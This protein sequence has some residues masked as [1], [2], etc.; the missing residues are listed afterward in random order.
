VAFVF[1]DCLGRGIAGAEQGLA[2][3]LNKTRLWERINRRP[4]NDRQRLVIKRML[5]GVEGFLTTS[6][7]CPSSPS[8]PLT[9][10]CAISKNYLA[11][12]PSSLIPA[13]DE[14]RATA[15]LSRRMSRCDE[16]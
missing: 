9:P 13:A 14:A 5:N 4:I 1:V 2:S 7:I 16:G 8:V 3:V 6:K 15:W 10:H 11:V 12:A